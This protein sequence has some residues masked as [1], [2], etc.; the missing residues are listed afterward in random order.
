MDPAPEAT[1]DD[2]L[3]HVNPK[4]PKAA[5]G[6]TLLAGGLGILTCVQIVTTVRILS[7]PWVPMPYVLLVLGGALVV[8]ARSVFL[9]RSWAAIGAMLVGALQG[10]ASLAWLVFAVANGFIALYAVWTPVWSLVAVGFCAAA[11]APCQRADRVREKLRAEG[12]GL[13]L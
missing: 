9:A 11:L 3:K 10:V 2:D 6:L 5:A 12:M 4:F 7:R 8:L 1:T 13:G